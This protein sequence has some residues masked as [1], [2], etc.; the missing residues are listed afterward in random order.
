MPITNGMIVNTNTDRV[1]RARRMNVELL[2]ANH[3]LDCLTCEQNGHCTLQDLA[4]DLG[5]L[6]KLAPQV[7]RESRCLR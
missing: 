5:L 2:L 4:Y 3:P 6:A 1:R 7:L